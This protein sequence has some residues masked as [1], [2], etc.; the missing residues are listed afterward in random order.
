[1]GLL[2]PTYP[3]EHAVERGAEDGER[4]HGPLPAVQVVHE[5]LSARRRQ[6]PRHHEPAR[7]TATDDIPASQ[8]QQEGT[9]GRVSRLYQPQHAMLMCSV[10]TSAA[11]R[12]RRP[13]SPGRRG[14]AAWPAHPVRHSG[15][16]G[17]AEHRRVSTPAAF[18]SSIRCPSIQRT[19]PASALPGSSPPPTCCT[20]LLQAS[21]ST[22]VSRSMARWA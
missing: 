6:R 21:S 13:G 19:G 16:H 4:A 14:R 17:Q 8:R 18:C 9:R 10:S 5:G 2:L 20:A 1:M 3:V 22:E 11:R 12:C 7:A 15:H